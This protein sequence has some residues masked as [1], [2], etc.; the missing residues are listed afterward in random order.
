MTREPDLAASE[1]RIGAGLSS[2]QDGEQ[3]WNVR[4]GASMPLQQ[5]RLGLRVSYARNE[6]PGYIDNAI[7]GSEDINSARQTSARAALRWDGD[8]VDVKL[9]ALHQ[10]ID[11]DNSAIVALDPATGTPIGGDFAGRAWQP[12]PFTKDLDLYSLTVDW[13]LGWADF[14]SASGWSNTD[15]MYQL[16]STVQFGEFA[17]LQLGLA[18]PGASTVIEEDATL[19]LSLPL[20][21]HIQVRVAEVEPMIETWR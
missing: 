13:D 4:F 14:V 6:V 18:E 9:A 15:T 8:S 20:R 21:G 2:V 17:N 11:S 10:G 16:D 3:G 12:T 7:D 5:D 19:T 1:F